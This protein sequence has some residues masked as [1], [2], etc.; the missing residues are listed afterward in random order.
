VLAALAADAARSQVDR[1]AGNLA[2]VISGR[3]SLS[4]LVHDLR[5]RSHQA[6]SA[7]AGRDVIDRFA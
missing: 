7:L 1:I 6:L 4:C 5:R 3:D 2:F